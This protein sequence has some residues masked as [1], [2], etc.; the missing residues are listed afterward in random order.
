MATACYEEAALTCQ[1]IR[2]GTAAR[3][4]L[5]HRAA[6]EALSPLRQDDEVRRTRDAVR[7]ILWGQPGVGGTVRRVQRGGGGAHEISGV[8]KSLIPAIAEWLDDARQPLSPHQHSV[9]LAQA[10]AP[11]R[12]PPTPPPA[13]VSATDA[14]ESVSNTTSALHAAARLHRMRKNAYVRKAAPQNVGSC[15]R[16]LTATPSPTPVRHA[17]HN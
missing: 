4:E 10:P 5:L 2:R 15:G 3:R 7:N 1:A 12:R 11:G 16:E 8:A 14:I 17:Q 13:D 6:S 9:R